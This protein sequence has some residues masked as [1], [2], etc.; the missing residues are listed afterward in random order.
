MALKIGATSALNLTL[1]GSVGSFSV[2]QGANGHSSIEVKYFLTHVGLDFES[3]TS[4]EVLQHLMPVRE[5]FD[6]GTLEF[7]ELMQRDID[8]ARVSSELIP[9]LLDP[10]SRDLV[11]LFP[12]IIVVVLPVQPGSNNLADRYPRVEVL[13]GKVQGQDELFQITRSGV[14]GQEAFEFQQPIAETRVLDHDFVRLLLNMNRIRLVIVDGQHRAMALLALYRNLKQEWSDARRAPFKDYYEEWTESYVHQ[15]DIRRISIPVMF[16]TFPSLDEDY[17]G[18]YDLKKAARA[19]FLTLNKTARKVTNSR[20]RLLDDNDLIALFMRDTLSAIKKKDIQSPRSLRAHN[21]ELD[22]LQDRTKIAD[23]IAVSGVDHVYYMVEHLILNNPSD[24]KGVKARSG[25]FWK[26]TDLGGNPSD[27]LNMLDLLGSE[28][29]TATHRDFFTVEVGEKLT[30]RFGQLYGNSIVQMFE[31]FEP[32]EA[33]NKAA[34]WLEKKLISE[35]QNRILP[36]LFEGQGIG[37]VFDQHIKNLREKNRPQRTELTQIIARLDATAHSTKVA[38]DEFKKMRTNYFLER[39]ADKSKIR[40]PNGEYI[41]GVTEFVSKILYDGIFRTVAF[42][43]A[44]V[45][46]FFGEF[47]RANVVRAQDHS[48]PLDVTATFSEFLSQMNAYFMPASSVGLKRL[49]ECIYKKVEGELKDWKIV[50]TTTTF[51]HVVYRGEMQPDEW[52]KYKYIMLELWHPSDPVLK[53]VVDAEREQ[54]R[55]QIYNSLRDETRKE[56][57]QKLSK[58]QEN[59]TPNEQKQIDIDA[60]GAFKGFLQTLGLSLSEIPT[61]KTMN[62]KIDK[63]TEDAE[64]VVPTEEQIWEESESS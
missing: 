62:E 30:E 25:K 7:D 39:I 27:R 63:D 45:C 48:P 33:H 10:R 60:Y 21:I 56:A 1:Q 23:P 9:Y 43:S 12:P 41:D 6:V 24:V 32:Y 26:R 4:T 28:A 44:L 14:V 15:F 53:N 20:N 51:R 29:A 42:Q 64:P 38:V 17:K 31:T 37:R 61:H 19:I 34:L 59:L 40:D 18:D 11:K 13:Q 5:M 49:V 16:C 2:G 36:I 35:S 8:D 22:Q 57:L 55:I 54:C 47:E 46:G 50:D 58:R 52:P 3:G